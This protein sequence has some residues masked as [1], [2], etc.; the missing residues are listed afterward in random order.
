MEV[1]VDIRRELPNCLYF[2]DASSSA[3]SL[4]FIVFRES[5]VDRNA[6]L[7]TFTES[8]IDELPNGGVKRV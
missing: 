7:F 8:I 5:R 1:K 2:A 3:L 4:V 6:I